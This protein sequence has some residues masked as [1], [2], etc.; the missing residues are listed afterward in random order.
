MDLPESKPWFVWTAALL[1]GLIYRIYGRFTVRHR[2][3]LRGLRAQPQ[4][5]VVIFNHSSHADVPAVGLALGVPLMRRVILPGKQ[6]LFD[7]PRFRWMM[8]QVGVVPVKRDMSDTAAVRVLLR[9]LQAGRSVVLAPEGTRSL[10]GKLLPFH[11]GF[12]RL[13]HK[14]GV[15][16]LPVGIQG[17]HR[18]LP[19]GASFPRP[20]KL[21]A[22]VGE[23]VDVRARLGPKPD[24]AAFQQFA[25]E[26]RHQ[27]AELIG[28]DALQ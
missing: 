20:R 18:V 10:D 6:E 5:L 26:M 7:D 12:A 19:K 21:T 11:P 4:P 22:V 13:A 17:A 23:P 3:R 9:A 1:L 8:K 16:V 27:I 25:N 28:Q 15:L 2:E 14:A 24:A